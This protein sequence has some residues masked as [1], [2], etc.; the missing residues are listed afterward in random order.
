METPAPRAGRRRRPAPPGSEES[1]QQ[2]DRPAERTADRTAERADGRTDGR[3]QAPRQR[4]PDPP[5]YGALLARWAADGRTLPGRRDP[6]WS[7]IASSP[8]WPNGPLYGSP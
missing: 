1:V 6:E 4:H 7:R 2:F 3:Q 8:I 5:I